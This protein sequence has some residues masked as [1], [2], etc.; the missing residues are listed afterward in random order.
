MTT[1]QK[2]AKK[3]LDLL[4]GVDCG[5]FGGCGFPTCKACAE[6]IADGESPALCP[7]CNN[8]A[9]AEIC[10]IMGVEPVEAEDKVAFVRCAGKAAASE[11]FTGCASCDEAKAMGAAKGEC[12][13]GC[14]GIG[15]CIERCKFDAMK[16]ENGHLVIDRDKCTGCGAC[17][18][19]C[20]QQIIEMIPREATN[21]IPCSSKA[22]ESETL[23]TCGFGCIG[24][25]DCVVSCPKGAIEMV[26]GSDVKGRYAKIDYD[27]CEG[28]VTCTVKCRKKI[29]VDTLHDLTKAKEEVALVRCVGGIRGKLKLKEMGV[30][31][32]ADAKDIDLDANDICEYSCLGLGDCVK[33]CRYDAISNESGVTKV[34]PDKCVGC[35]DCMRACPR[36]KII[37]VPYKG[38]KQIV[39]SS[40]ADPKRRME[41]CGVG[42]IGCGDCVENCPEQAITMTDGNPFIDQDKCTN[43]GIC[44]YLCSRSLIKERVVPE[45]NYIQMKAAEID[46]EQTAGISSGHTAGADAGHTAGNDAE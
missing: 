9:V 37:M 26:V 34:D 43:C 22:S 39:C 4:P 29:I 2:T 42:C 45:Y 15:T 11:R 8:E 16:V 40:K 20:V 1:S 10:R 36:N 19:A 5:G 17:V 31:S 44:T 25:G 21:F 12:K 32:C 7:A 28:C 46:A 18:G 14:F 23:A 41:V 6:A 33:V 24:C 38:V 27:K 35:G 3:I 13:Y 30:E